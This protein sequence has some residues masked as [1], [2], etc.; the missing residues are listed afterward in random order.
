MKVLVVDDEKS[1][2]DL[3]VRTLKE[4]GYTVETASSG[5]AALALLPGDF[6]IIL[7]DLDMPGKT[8]GVDLTRVARSKSNCDVIIMTGFPD[9]STAIEAVREGAYDYLVKPFSPDTLRMSLDRCSAKRGLSKELE[10]EK[11]LRAELKKAYTEL[12]SMQKVRDLFGQFTTPDVAN[13]V[14]DH[15]DDF[16]KRGARREVTILFAD[17]RRFTPF[18]SRVS[19]EEAVLALN[20]IFEVLVSAVRA[21]GGEVNK[22]MGDGLMAIFGAPRDMPNHAAAAACAALKA[23]TMF[24]FLAPAGVGENGLAVGFALNTGEVIAGCM[25]TK[26]RTEYSVIGSPVNLAA[27]IEKVCG[28][29]EILMGPTTADR[30]RSLFRLEE[31]GPVDL[32]GFPEPVPLWSL[33]S[34]KPSVLP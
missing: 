2:R 5:D 13:F 29:H 24:Q 9:L 26:L 3:A 17:V 15:P 16:W 28:P 8:N 20:N 22:F 11:A 34:P 27:R 10:S 18:A 14:M 4:A 32:A 6:E 1:M 25:G 33:L 12:S 23:R 21:E 7:T 30:V 19:P 31:K